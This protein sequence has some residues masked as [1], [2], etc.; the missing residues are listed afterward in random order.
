MLYV[1]SI[2]KT[3]NKKKG[4]LLYSFLFAL[5][6]FKDLTFFSGHQFTLF[7]IMMAVESAFLTSI[8]EAK[9]EQIDNLVLPLFMFSMLSWID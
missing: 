2:Y 1:Y 9:T 3:I 8:L 5:I 7:T 6:N 4:Y